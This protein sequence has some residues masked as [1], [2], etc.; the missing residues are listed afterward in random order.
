LN[1]GI[2]ASLDIEEF[3]KVN[4]MADFTKYQQ[5][6]ISASQS[7]GVLSR[8]TV[9]D[10]PDLPGGA[11]CAAG[12]ILLAGVNLEGRGLVPLGL[13]AGVDVL[14]ME[15][16]DCKIGGVEAPFGPNSPD[17]PDGQMPLSMAPPHSGVEGSQLFL[18]LVALD[19]N[20][21]GGDAGFQVS[22]I[23]DRVANVEEDHAVSGSYLPYPSATVSKA[24]F[25]VTFDAPIT[26][27]ALARVEL[28]SGDDTWLVYA[29]GNAT[30]IQLP[31]VARPRQIFTS[32]GSTYVLGMGME[33]NYS[34]VWT[35][36]SGKTLNRMFYT[37]TSFVVQECADTGPAPCL[38]Q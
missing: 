23:V 37:A 36:G 22:A 1:H 35:F 28:Q 18:L 11:A 16:A 2:V 20:S 5:A 30:N 3:P 15:A 7:L 26:G 25:S 6:N 29:P 19:P 24:N 9:P 12:A 17:L 33:G 38:I 10:L 27:V 32:L 4:N 8:V 13:T 31:V 34:E 14:D 21:L